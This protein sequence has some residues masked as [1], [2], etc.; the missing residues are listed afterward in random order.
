MKSRVH[1]TTLGK[2]T[3][4]QAA[5]L[6][7]ARSTTK[8]SKP[9]SYDR[10]ARNDNFFLDLLADKLDVLQRKSENYIR[11][12]DRAAATAMQNSWNQLHSIYNGLLNEKMSRQTTTTFFDTKGTAIDGDFIL[13]RIQK[14][15]DLA[16]A[17]MK[18][19][20][21]VSINR[22]TAQIAQL[23]SQVRATQQ[24]LANTR[25][26]LEKCEQKIRSLNT[27]NRGRL[28]DKEAEIN[29]LISRIDKA[30]DAIIA[31]QTEKDQCDA[32]I[33]RL[34][35]EIS[36]LQEPLVLQTSAFTAGDGTAEPLSIDFS[37]RSGVLKEITERDNLIAS[38][39]DG[40]A[41]IIAEGVE[42]AKDLNEANTLKLNE[43]ELR[44]AE[45]AEN[46]AT[47]KKLFIGALLLAIAGGGTAYYMSRK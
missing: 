40:R 26:L 5:Q 44:A 36:E 17:N 20:A 45:S 46:A 7:A 28:D 6:K 39:T 10:S 9:M 21:D 47:Y 22:K 33:A 2:V 1:A 29:D 42:R 30:N 27:S 18:K 43:I 19:Y 23:N 37:N 15:M 16:D 25:R 14:A 34:Q 24:S 32:S 8:P 13:S 12:G 31:L 38:L 41:G 35:T 4:Q 3:A 11:S